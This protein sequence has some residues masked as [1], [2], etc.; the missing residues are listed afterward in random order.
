MSCAI[1]KRDICLCALCNS[2]ECKDHNPI[3][4]DH[5]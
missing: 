5:L 2:L 3:C 4:G 1:C